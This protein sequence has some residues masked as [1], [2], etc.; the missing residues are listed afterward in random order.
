[1]CWCLSE[2]L[3]IVQESRI[4]YSFSVNTGNLNFFAEGSSRYGWCIC[5]LLLETLLVTFCAWYGLDGEVCFLLSEAFVLVTFCAW[6]GLERRCLLSPFRGF[7]VDNGFVRDRVWKGDVCLFLSEAFV[8]VTFCA[9]QGLG[10]VIHFSSLATVCSAVRC[11]RHGCGC[12]VT[13]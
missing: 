1:M 12:M 3:V 4:F 8:L 7:C 6:Q 11:G 13:L 9:W 10:R 5:F 2:V